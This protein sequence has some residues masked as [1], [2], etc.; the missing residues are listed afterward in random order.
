MTQH[1]QMAGRDVARSQIRTGLVATGMAV[2]DANVIT[3][4]AMH[5]VDQAIESLCRTTETLDGSKWFTCHTIALQ[6]LS[7]I[8]THLHQV[9]I[10]EADALGLGYK[11]TGVVTVD[12][13]S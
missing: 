3:D 6:A 2:A 12:T 13:R 8:A 11:A 4:V 1:T 7:G 10:A 5:A 9:A